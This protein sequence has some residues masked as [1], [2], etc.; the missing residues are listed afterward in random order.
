MCWSNLTSLG[1]KLL[2]DLL[3]KQ[4]DLADLLDL[5]DHGDQD[6]DVVQRAGP[7]DGP[8]LDPEQLPVPEGETDGPQ[9]QRRVGLLLDLEL[10]Q[11][12]LSADVDRPDIDRAGIGVLGEAGNRPQK[13][14]SSVGRV[15]LWR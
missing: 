6:A 8:Q 7:E 10:G 3:E 9:P 1:P 14:S 15:D 2:L 13:W 12:L 5:R 11:A 4:L